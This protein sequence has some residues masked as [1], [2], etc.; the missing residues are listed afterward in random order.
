MVAEPEGESSATDSAEQNR[1]VGIHSESTG[2]GLP[3]EGNPRGRQ[4][5]PE[6]KKAVNL[7]A[8]LG[9]DLLSSIRLT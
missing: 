2:P 1:I 8:D 6:E 4:A 5:D 9:F 3:D 7:L